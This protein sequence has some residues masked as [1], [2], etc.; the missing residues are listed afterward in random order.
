[1]VDKFKV[2]KDSADPILKERIEQLEQLV[3]V[4]IQKYRSLYY[5]LSPP[6]LHQNG[7]PAALELLVEDV[8]KKHGFKVILKTSIDR[9]PDSGTCF[10]AVH[11]HKTDTENPE[12][13]RSIL[14]EVEVSDKPENLVQPKRQ[15]ILL[16]DDHAVIRKGL[17]ILLEDID[18]FQVVAEAAEGK[19]A[20][21]MASE[22]KPD[23]ILMDI[24]MPEKDGIEAT[25]E[26]NQLLPNI[27]IIGLSIHD[28]PG[29]KDR[30][31]IRTTPRTS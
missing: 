13:I 19:Q 3:C 31:I 7:W 22:M 10:F 12:A 15:R 29:T 2:K 8:E 4:S 16:S 1:L 23:V 30:M 6:V 11:K 14:Q 26:I 25:A 21:R 5:E 18:V 27:R 24:S 20:V 28:D 9:E 17:S